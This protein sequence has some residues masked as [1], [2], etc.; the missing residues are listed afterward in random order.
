MPTLTDIASGLP[1]DKGPHGYLPHYERH[2]GALRDSAFDLLE[3][4]VFKGAG[5]QMWAGW[6][7]RATLLGVDVEPCGPLGDR[8]ET[9]VCDACVF[10]PPHPFD[11]IIDDANHDATQI[12]TTLERLWPA[13]APGG[14]YIV[15]DLQVQSP[16]WPNPKAPSGP[17][18]LVW[19]ERELRTLCYGESASLAAIH[20]YPKIVFLEKA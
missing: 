3:I 15:E 14:F 8:I 6:A 16:S 17:D 19:V 5:L 10:E 18:V 9:V 7:P 2:L 20:A 13:V 4:G 1:T 12:V 11:V